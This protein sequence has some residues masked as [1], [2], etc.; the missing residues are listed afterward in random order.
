MTLREEL[1][2][3]VAL[4]PTE[5]PLRG[6]YRRFMDRLRSKTAGDFRALIERARMEAPTLSSVGLF[7]SVS[8]HI[9]TDSTTFG[10]VTYTIDAAGIGYVAKSEPPP[11]SKPKRV[12]KP[13]LKE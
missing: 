13:K 5:S 3:A 11:P 1:D 10:G 9:E 6:E 7:L 8:D 12:R 2:S 4:L